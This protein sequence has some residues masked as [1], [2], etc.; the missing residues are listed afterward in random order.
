[1]AQSVEPNLRVTERRVEIR[2]RAAGMG[3]D[4]G[5]IAQ[6]VDRFYERVLED[7][8]L[9]PI[10]NEAITGSWEPHL[11]KMKDFWASVAFNAGRYSGKPVPVHQRLDGLTRAHFARWL[12]LFRA[13]LEDL[14]AS[15]DAVDYMMQ[16]AEKIAESLKMA[17]FGMPGVPGYRG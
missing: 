11:A 17:V 2:A 9:A 13:T 16:K 3:I 14:G 7:D 6:M 10:F 12:A 4:D 8:L 1:M 5:F 15:A